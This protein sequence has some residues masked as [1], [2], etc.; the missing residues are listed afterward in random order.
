MVYKMIAQGRLGL[1]AFAA[2]QTSS[3]SDFQRNLQGLM[4]HVLPHLLGQANQ[5]KLA[6]F[7]AGSIGSRGRALSNSANIVST[8]VQVPK[9]STVITLV[10]GCPWFYV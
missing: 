1:G 8:A 6:P 7:P 4:P 2:A 3:L 5:V 10:K 9:N